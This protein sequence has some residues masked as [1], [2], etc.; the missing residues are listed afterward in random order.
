MHWAPPHVDPMVLAYVP[1]SGRLPLI[2]GRPGILFQS[3]LW[4]P[5]TGGTST[6]PAMHLFDSIKK[7]DLRVETMVGGHGGVGPFKELQNAVEKKK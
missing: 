6:P 3:D 7:L 2:G 5:G 1:G 4:F